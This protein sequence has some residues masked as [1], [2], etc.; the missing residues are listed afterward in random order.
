MREDGAVVTR[1]EGDGRGEGEKGR[2]GDG[3]DLGVMI[4]RRREKVGLRWRQ[5]E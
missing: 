5:R 3:I 4:L 1:E 2:W